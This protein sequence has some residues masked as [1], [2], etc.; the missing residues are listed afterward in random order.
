[1][2]D[3]QELTD[4]F[5]KYYANIKQDLQ[6]TR[7]YDRFNKS[8]VSDFLKEVGDEKLIKEF[9]ALKKEAKKQAAKEFQALPKLYD[10]LVYDSEKKTISIKE[11]SILT[12]AAIEQFK[13][14]AFRINNRIHGVYN[15]I[16]AAKIE[17]YWWGSLVMQYHKHLYPGFMKRFRTRGFYNE[18]RETVEKGS[19]LTFMNYIFGEFNGIGKKLKENHD[20][21]VVMGSIK[22]IL[23]AAGQ[24]FTKLGTRWNLL[25]DW[26]KRNIRRVLGDVF[27]MASAYLMALAI[28]AIF[29]DDDVK[30]SDALGTL[31]YSADRIFAESFMWNPVGLVNEGKTL[32]SS[33]I[34]ATN[35]YNDLFT[36]MGLGIKYFVD[37]D[38]KLTY[39]TGLY[40]G[41]N[42]FGVVLSRNIPGYRVYKR[43]SNM[44]RN[45][46]YYRINDNSLNMKYAKKHAHIIAPDR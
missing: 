4:K 36:A 19:Y 13:S 22:T 41:Q 16:G 21:E 43:L 15:K 18:A 8:I 5:A 28:Y 3:N 9:A 11:G 17:Q 7:E 20:E 25:E 1:M 31:V 35:S 27:G 42:K 12:E 33:P 30:K 37:D 14:K 34:A 45:N 29:D 32:W 6:V 26:E 44:S 24:T 2:S 40:K 10:E 46:Q 23:K 39:T 38:F